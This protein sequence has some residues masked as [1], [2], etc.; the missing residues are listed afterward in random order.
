MRLTLCA[1]VLLGVCLMGAPTSAAPLAGAISK[2]LLTQAGGHSLVLQVKKKFRKGRRSYRS[3]RGYYGDDGGTAA[4]A[5][6]F[7]L[8]LGAMIA[9]EAQR[10]QA[11][12]YCSRRYRSF[13]PTTMTFRG[14]DGRLYR[15]P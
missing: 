1:G 2:D 3:Y 12:E 5:G 14:Y 6:L 13:D 11:I 10:Q 7:G 8:F 9:N 15:C 4:A